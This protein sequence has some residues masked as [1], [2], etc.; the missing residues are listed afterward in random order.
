MFFRKMQ[1]VKLMNIKEDHWILR[2]V[3]SAMRYV[4]EIAINM[5]RE[6]K[7]SEICCKGTGEPET[8]VFYIPGIRNREESAC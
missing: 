3:L 5:R 8:R 4:Q 6:W 2:F 1:Y 7:M